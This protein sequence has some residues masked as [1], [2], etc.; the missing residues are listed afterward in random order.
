MQ[1]WLVP[2]AYKWRETV[3]LA[4]GYERDG[5]QTLTVRYEDLRNDTHAVLGTMLGFVGVCV[6]S[7]LVTLLMPASGMLAASRP[8]GSVFLQPLWRDIISCLLYFITQATT[9]RWPIVCR[10]AGRRA[11]NEQQATRWATPTA[12]LSQHAP[13]PPPSSRA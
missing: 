10:A 12:A 5:M 3:Q 13:S 9:P 11:Q 6:N 8:C 7:Q 1:N 4:E 2:Y